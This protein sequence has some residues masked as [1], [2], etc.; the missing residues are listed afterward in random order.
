MCG[1]KNHDHEVRHLLPDLQRYKAECGD[2][3]PAANNAGPVSSVSKYAATGRITVLHY[4]DSF[5]KMPGPSDGMES[6]IR[7]IPR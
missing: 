1:N 3:R 7:R 4:R 2:V 6:L 5:A